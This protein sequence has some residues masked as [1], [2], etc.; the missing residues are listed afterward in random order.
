MRTK[1]SIKNVIIAIIMNVLTV[2]IGLV[3]Q[4][5]FILFLGTEY[6]GIN[7]LFTNI[8]SMLGIVEL[9]IGAAIIYNLY[10]PLAKKDNEKI[11]SLMKFYKVS[12]RIIALAVMIL[13]LL[14]MPFLSKITGTVNIN[15]NIY[16]IYAIY[17]IDVVF[18]YCLTYKR[19]IIYAN[20]ENYIIN[21]VHIGYLLILNFL[22]FLILIY[23]KNFYLY[24]IIKVVMRILENLVLTVI[25]NKKYDILIEKDCKKLDIETKKDITKKVKALF[26]HKI[27]SYVVL[28]TDNILLSNI[29]GIAVVGL[30]SNYYLI[31]NTLNNFVMQLFAGVTASIGNLLT[32]K[33]K[34]H[35]FEVYKNIRFFASWLATFFSVS[36]YLCI[37]K[38][39]IIWLGKSYLMS[40]AIVLSLTINMYLTMYRYSITGFKE[41]AGIFYEDRFMPLFEA[42]INFISSIIFGK[43]IGVAGIFIGTILSN[44]FLHL[45]SYYKYIYRKVFKQSSFEYYSYFIKSFVTFIVLL[46]LL[47]SLNNIFIIKNTLLSLLFSAIMST[48][49]VN[50]I[51]IIINA[52]SNELKYYLNILKKTKRKNKINDFNI[53]K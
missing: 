8:V 19:S 36:F 29:F 30:Y 41:A 46:V 5:L 22:Q 9:G 27:G 21:I 3:S 17:L 15:E 23:T 12:Y 44:L 35:N 6:L 51:L 31:I 40:T 49:L 20:Q 32:L 24:L 10:E 45:V 50:G 28:G 48:I 11:K 13:G 14:L 43:L 16:I 25:A 33:D 26:F 34:K 39:I 52:K 2:I 53:Y 37:Q 7:G 42:T 4:K 18:S 47:S 38:F 1:K